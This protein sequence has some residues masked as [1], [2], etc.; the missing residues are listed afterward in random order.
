MFFLELQ[1]PASGSKEALRA[2]Q[3]KATGAPK[4]LARIE[5]LRLLSKLEDLK[6]LSLLQV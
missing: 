6:I 2:K 4:M 1:S 3:K 5:Q